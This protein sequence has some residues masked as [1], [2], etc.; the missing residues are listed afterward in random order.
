MKFNKTEIMGIINLTPDSF[1]G[2]GLLIQKDPALSALEQ[3][4]HFIEQ[5][6]TILDIGAE[7]T[8]PGASPVDE[9]EELK[10]VIPA[11]QT[12]RNA[13]PKITISIDTYKASVAEAALKAGANWIND[14]W[15]FRADPEMKHVAAAFQAPSI[16]MHNRSTPN[17]TKIEKNL[18]GHYIGVK[19]SN[20][21]ENI[22]SEL[23]L[24]VNLAL[25]A[26]LDK[27]KII[28]DPGIGFGKTV[29][30][31]LRVLK[32]LSAFKSLGFPLLIGPSR[33]S[34]V[35]YTLNLLPSERLE[36]TIAAA[37]IGFLNGADIIRV[38]D[39]EAIFRAI[40]FAESV[41]AS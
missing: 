37:V 27:D 2:D 39:V 36:G 1:S 31:N 20:L 26:G 5:G 8:R 24:S 7:S 19:Y 18:G 21:I 23:M 25:E 15:G 40:R 41:Q 17:N 33:K 11:V 12:I 13:F 28:I 10:R 32:D 29:E 38:H 9:E 16:L 34:F 4:G 14:V 35:G 3:A 6:A 30:Q 22:K